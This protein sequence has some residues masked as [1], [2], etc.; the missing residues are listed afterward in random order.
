MQTVQIVDGQFSD[1]KGPRGGNFTGEDIT[2][3]SYF[4]P[5]KKM[6]KL[7]I[8]TDK[9]FKAFYITV[10]TKNFNELDNDDKVILD[11][12]DEPKTFDRVQSGAVFATRALAN[13]AVT[14]SKIMEAEQDAIIAE[15]KTASELAT[16]LAKLANLKTIQDKAV[17]LDLD[18]DAV[19]SLV[20]SI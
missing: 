17:E 3:E 13:E 10:T 19:K 4:I 20:A 5:K 8:K 18:A 14:A 15:S 1:T 7:G 12:N 9:E 16:G 6:H 11:A 2:G